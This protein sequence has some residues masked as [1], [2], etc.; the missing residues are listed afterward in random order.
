[1][2]V[3]VVPVE[4][5]SQLKQFIE[6][7]HQLYKNEAAYVPALD[8][9]RNEFFDTE[10]NPFY[11]GAKVQLFLAV[12]GH[13]VCGRIA[14]CVNYRHNDF[15]GEKTG[16]FGFL[17]C[18]DD[19][20]IASRLLKVAMIT[21]KKE[22]MEA[23]RGPMN[24]STNHEIGFLVE[25]FEDPPQVMM[26]WNKPYL[27]A[28][29][30]KF[31]L[32]KVMD[33]LGF[34]IDEEALSLERHGKVTKR[35][36]ERQKIT[37]RTIRMNDFDNEVKLINRIYNEAWERNWGFVPME[38]EEFNYMAKNLKELVDPK[39]VIIAMHGERPV[40]FCLALPDINQALIHTNGHLLPF[41]LFQI[42]WHTKVSNKVNRLRMIT[43]GVVHDYHKKGVDAALYVHT[44]Q[45][46]MKA[47]YVSAE[48]SWILETN[49]L[50]VAAATA[51]GCRLYKRYRIM[52]MP[53]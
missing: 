42:L 23:M 20:E 4:S 32:K 53:I 30:E 33:L 51:L 41:G 45:A 50:M 46:G 11:K 2:Q 3:D 52:Q 8:I 49:E 29:A 17:D 47:G 7:P 12:R 27:P 14:T 6:Y 1:M 35:L 13:V 25:N 48:L 43:M 26:T 15:H 5:K 21:L 28:L 10:K 9:E 19:Y 38:L 39:L 31:G 36:L 40:G 34:Y 16:F 37:I 22:G 24:F 18:P 44:A